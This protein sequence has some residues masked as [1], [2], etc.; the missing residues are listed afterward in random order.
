MKLRKVL[1]ITF[2]VLFIISCWGSNALAA[3]NKDEMIYANLKFNGQVSSINV[4]NR[5]YSLDDDEKLVDYGKYESISNLTNTEK[6]TVKGDKISWNNTEKE[7]FYEGTLNAPL[8]MTI[9]VKYFLDGKKV[10]GKSL[11]GASGKLTIEVS[12]TQNKK[13]PQKVREALIAQITMK[14]DVDK[15]KNL[16]VK[17]GSTVVV[18]KQINIT[19]TIMPESDGKLHITCDVQDF[20]MPGISITLTNNTMD[21]GDVGEKVTELE[22]GFTE[23]VEGMDDMVEGTQELKD[24]VGGIVKAVKDFNYGLYKMSEGG[25]TLRSG[26]DSY[27]S[28]LVTTKNGMTTLAT[29]S[30]DIRAGLDELNTN[31]TPIY[32]GYLGTAAGLNQLSS[33]HGNLVLLAQGILLDPTATLREKQLAN[34]VIAEAAGIEALAVGL[35]TLNTNLN[36]YHLGLSSIASGYHHLDD[37]IKQLP[38][39]IQE[40]INGFNGLKTGVSETT[41]GITDT[42]KGMSRFYKKIK[43]LPDDVLT[44]VDGQNEF[45]D[46]ILQAKDELGSDVNNMLPKSSENAVSFVMPDKNNPVTVQYFMHTPDITI[47]DDKNDE[48]IVVEKRNFWQ[49]FWDL[50]RNLFNN[51]RDK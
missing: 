33:D 21:F 42:S 40:L 24:G 37:G 46:G 43:S 6:P 48:P 47:A 16:D 12:L 26:M 45:R 17:E 32:Q 39:S 44:M 18:G 4:V 25:S 49:R 38:A 30:K 27:A 2:S 13:S 41:L 15:I 29:S 7:L 22:D 34:G 28:G 20:E 8:P 11:A 9:E 3:T 36:K 51:N 31:L 10:D 5:L 23:M 35:D 14:L 19:Q 50:F 1:G